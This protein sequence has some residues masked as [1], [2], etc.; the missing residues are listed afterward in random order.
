MFQSRINLF[1]NLG[2]L[3]WLF[4]AFVTYIQCYIARFLF[5]N[6]FF[7]AINKLGVSLQQKQHP[8]LDH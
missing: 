1:S 2:V 3:V 6:L 4:P 8:S 7:I 5:L